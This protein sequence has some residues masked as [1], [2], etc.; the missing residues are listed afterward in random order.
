MYMWQLTHHCLE[1][2]IDYRM[3][4]YKAF[5]PILGYPIVV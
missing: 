2:E 5:G 4:D 1:K 3:L